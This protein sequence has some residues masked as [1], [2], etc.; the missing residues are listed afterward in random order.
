V[1]NE[2][3]ISPPSKVSLSFSALLVRVKNI[4]R[5]GMHE[6]ARPE[7]APRPRSAEA[8]AISDRGK[9][10]LLAGSDQTVPFTPQIL[11][12][13]ADRTNSGPVDLV[14]RDK[15]CI[16]IAFSVPSA[17]LAELRQMIETE[18]QF[19]SPFAEA[20]SLSFWTARELANG[21][22]QIQAAVFLRT[23]VA[24]LLADLKANGVPVGQV[25]RE[26]ATVEFSA[27]PVWATGARAEP[28]AWSIVKGLSRTLKLT[29]A[30]SFL[31]LASA[32]ALTL[33]LSLG[34]GRLSAEAEA[35]RASLSADAQTSASVRSLEQTL[36]RSA[37]RLAMTGRLTSLL[38]DGFWLDQ[39]AVEQDTVT[40]TGFGPSAAEVT[41]LLS[42]MPELSDIIFASPVTRDNTQSLERYRISANFVGS[43][44]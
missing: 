25:W 43:A 21:R 41:R 14:F 2:T 29:L 36:D 34:A 38:P 35:A 4:L 5:Q 32:T 9:F 33:S 18:V 28:T 20:V 37:D 11:S 30:G 39:L 40:L 31:L 42:T 13:L 17:P 27:F 3:G 1:T 15:S 44:P 16:D 8:I 19:R 10:L 24:E 22:W 12:G 6:L 7:D 23:Q 26:S